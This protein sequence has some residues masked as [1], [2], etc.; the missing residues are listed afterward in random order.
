MPK[1]IIGVKLGNLGNI[2]YIVIV[3]KLVIDRRMLR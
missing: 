3:D 2:Q 1:M